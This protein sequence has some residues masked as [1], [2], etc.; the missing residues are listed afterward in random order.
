MG[1]EGH[2]G[3][4]EAPV[5]VLEVGFLVQISVFACLKVGDGANAQPN[6]SCNLFDNVAG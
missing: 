4:C 3:G 5:E 2:N 1:V 6:L